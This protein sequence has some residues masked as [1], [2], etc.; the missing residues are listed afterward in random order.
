MNFFKNNYI[1]KAKDNDFVIKFLKKV[2]ACLSPML[3]LE[4]EKKKKNMSEE[5]ES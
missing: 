3:P 1:I 5:S 4:M 2:F